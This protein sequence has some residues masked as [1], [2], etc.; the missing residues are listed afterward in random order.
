MYRVGIDPDYNYILVSP[1]EDN[2]FTVPYPQFKYMLEHG[3]LSQGTINEDNC[4]TE[5]LF[6]PNPVSHAQW[7]VI[8]LSGEMGICAEPKPEDNPAP[9][10]KQQHHVYLESL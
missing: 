10:L 6:N 9:E 5:F 7:E 8:P 4:R 3:E 2:S 1:H